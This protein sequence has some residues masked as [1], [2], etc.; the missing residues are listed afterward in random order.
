MQ[1]Q[2]GGWGGHAQIGAHLVVPSHQQRHS[3]GA[4]LQFAP[5][6]ILVSK[7]CTSSSVILE[8]DISGTQIQSNQD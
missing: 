3:E 1:G 4:A 7:H 2:W 8:A 5:A 6:V